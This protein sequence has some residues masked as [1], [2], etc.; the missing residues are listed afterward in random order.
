MWFT[1]LGHSCVRLE[2][3]GAILVI[4]PGALRDLADRS[5][6][7]VRAARGASAWTCAR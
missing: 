4:D 2:K 7:L 6:K 3:D 1:K 5:S